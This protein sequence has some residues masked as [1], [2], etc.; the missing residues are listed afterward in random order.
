MYYSLLFLDSSL[1]TTSNVATVL[2]TNQCHQNGKIVTKVIYITL[3]CMRQKHSD[4]LNHQ[5]F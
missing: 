3:C 5:Y 4:F 2:Y 1:A